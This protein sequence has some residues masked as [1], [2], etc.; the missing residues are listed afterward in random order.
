MWLCI[1]GAFVSLKNDAAGRPSAQCALPPQLGRG[2]RFEWNRRPP[3]LAICASAVLRTAG[4]C[5][6]PLAIRDMRRVSTGERR[7]QLLKAWQGAFVPLISNRDAMFHSMRNQE[8]RAL[9]RKISSRRTGACRH[10]PNESI[11]GHATSRRSIDANT[12]YSWQRPCR[13]ESLMHVPRLPS[14]GLR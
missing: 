11:T 1:A 13:L 10:H 3:L 9:S 14:W 4:R 8:C 5:Q 6:R 12:R 2:W 7:S